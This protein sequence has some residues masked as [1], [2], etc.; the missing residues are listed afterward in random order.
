MYNLILK[1]D[2]KTAICVVGKGAE[3][4]VKFQELINRG[5]K[6]ISLKIDQRQNELR[7]L[8]NQSKYLI[9]LSRSEGFPTVSIESMYCGTPV[10]ASN[11]PQFKEQITHG[12]NGYICS[13]ENMGKII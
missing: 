4:E 10:I 2:K 9:L 6:N 3:F 13:T 7:K 1:L 5:Y 8:Y 12:K 11:I